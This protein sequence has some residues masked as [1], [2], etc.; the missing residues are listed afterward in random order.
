LTDFA[1]SIGPELI[2]IGFVSN[3][4]NALS[5]AVRTAVANSALLLTDRVVLV[6][7]SAADV[8]INLP[9]ALSVWDATTNVS[10]QF[11][12]KKITT[13]VN[14]VNIVPSGVETIDGNTAY[15]IIGP[16]LGAVTLVSD[17]ANWFVVGV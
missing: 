7:T 15:N 12:M 14:K 6:D 2:E 8:A 1:S 4:N 17:G 10:Q 11:T 13:D 9:S 5:V 3:A 16:S